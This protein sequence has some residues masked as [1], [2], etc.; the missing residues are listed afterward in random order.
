MT[1]SVEWG[2]TPQRT[3]RKE[4]FN[5]PAMTLVAIDDSKSG[6]GSGSNRKIAFNKAAIAT[7]GL[8]GDS[9]AVSFGFAKNE[10]GN[11]QIF[12]KVVTPSDEK[13]VYN[14]NKSNTFSNKRL[15]NHVS[16]LMNLDN[17]VENTF[18]LSETADSSV[19]SLEVVSETT[20]VATPM[21]DVEEDTATATATEEIIEADGVIGAPT[22]EEASEW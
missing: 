15:F 18:K 7:L 14:L 22:T 20:S 19:Y 11:D 9:S 10:S 4:K 13:S 17:S 16:K 8:S 5:F 1:N 2:I 6:K 12:L 3:V 21:N